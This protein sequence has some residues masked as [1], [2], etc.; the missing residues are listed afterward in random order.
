MKFSALLLAAAPLYGAEIFNYRAEWR[1][2]HAGNVRLELDNAAARMKIVTAGLAGSLYPVNDDYA[3]QFRQ[4]ACTESIFFKM[5]EGKRKREVKV[6]FPAS[7]GK[8]AYREMDLVAN[9]IARETDLDVPACVHDAIAALVKLRAAVPAPGTRITL[10]VSD[11]RKFANVE[12]KALQREKIKIPA[13]EFTAIRYEAGL[14]NDVIYRRKARMYF[15][16]SDD[17][18]RLPLQVRIQ[19]AFYLGTVTIQLEKEDRQ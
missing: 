11:G 18:R 15:W 12:I 7:P 13:G 6:T 3:V 4:G 17:S 2:L 1:L 8:S 14:F 10:P 9:K 5:D 19:M 16:L